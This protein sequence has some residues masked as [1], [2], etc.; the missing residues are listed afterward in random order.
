MKHFK[1]YTK[2]DILSLTRVRRF[3]TKL[4]ERIA[5]V[6]DPANLQESLLSSPCKYVLVG[7]P[8]DI[9]VRA[10]LGTGGADT[11]WLPFLHSFLNIQSN[12]FFSGEEL[13]LLGHFDFGDI[14]FLID[15]NAYNQEEKVDAYRHA[16]NFIDEEVEKL[17]KEIAFAGKIPVVIGGGHNNAYPIIKGVAK[18]LF[19]AEKIPLAQINSINLDA[20]ADFRP[21]EGR[22]SGN[23]FKYAEDEGFLGK[24]AIIGLHENYIP[25][26][27]LME[28][29]ENPFIQYISYEDIFIHERKNFIQAVAHATGFTEDSFTGIELDVDCIEKVLS[30]ALTPSGINALLARQYINFTATDCKTAYLFISEGACQLIDGK[31]DDST[32]K[33]ISYL[34]SDFI[35]AQTRVYS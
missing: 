28:I 10:N 14:K 26:N 17:L 1:F 12:D 29:H 31:K 30:S 25:Q 19:K 20:Q 23:A 3:E 27:I 22:H 35:K 21:M 5:S 9:G 33:L 7:I 4:G 15:Q 6:K 32:G 34:V 2:A 24:Y 18:G 11:A 16:V 8:E 13:M